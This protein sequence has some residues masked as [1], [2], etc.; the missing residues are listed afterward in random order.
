MVLQFDLLKYYKTIKK[1]ITDVKMTLSR[2]DEL[3][4]N[5]NKTGLFQYSFFG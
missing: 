5:P 3:Y 1:T 2:L 4:F